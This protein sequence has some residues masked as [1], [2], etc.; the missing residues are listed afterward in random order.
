MCVSTDRPRRL[1]HRKTIR[2]RIERDLDLNYDA[3]D[4][5]GDTPN[6]IPAAEPFSRSY[7]EVAESRSE[8]VEASTAQGTSRAEAMS[9]MGYTQGHV[10]EGQV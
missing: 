9:S 10:K 8:S 1:N 6:W 5:V 2:S 3:F 7:S 4:S